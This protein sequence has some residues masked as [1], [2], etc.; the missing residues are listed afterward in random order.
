MIAD[1]ASSSTTLSPHRSHAD[2]MAQKVPFLFLAGAV[3][4]VLSEEPGSDK[5]QDDDE[6]EKKVA[7]FET[8]LCSSSSTFSTTLHKDNA[9][10]DDFRVILKELQKQGEGRNAAVAAERSKPQQQHNKNGDQKK[11]KKKH[12]HVSFDDH[13]LNCTRI[14]ERIQAPDE[15]AEYWYSKQEKMVIAYDYLTILQFYRD[16]DK[17]DDDESDS[18][19]RDVAEF[20]KVLLKLYQKGH[21]VLRQVDQQVLTRHYLD[22]D[23]DDHIIDGPRGLE[24]LILQQESGK[25]VKK[26]L[27]HVL[28]AQKQHRQQ[29]RQKQQ[30]CSAEESNNVVEQHFLSLPPHLLLAACPTSPIPEPTL[31]MVTE[32]AVQEK[33]REA[34]LKTSILSQRFSL[35]LAQYDAVVAA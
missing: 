19:D 9:V 8:K 34:S 13:R 25:R 33:L 20:R 35:G 17:C 11:K 22:D 10:V 32:Q 1:V 5:D 4:L 6:K 27:R 24:R 23:D 14:V 31:V 21:T 7:K 15:V 30:Q 29:H 2:V 26:H 18:L 16:D 12:H 28:K 3:D